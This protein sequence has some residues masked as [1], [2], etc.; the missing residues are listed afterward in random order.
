MQNPLKH[1]FPVFKYIP[2]RT[3]MYDDTGQKFS[4]YQII[5][6]SYHKVRTY[7]LNF[8]SAHNETAQGKLNLFFP[9]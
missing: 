2:V 7:N 5:F 3:K 6:T 8:T 4:H 9:Q 1:K